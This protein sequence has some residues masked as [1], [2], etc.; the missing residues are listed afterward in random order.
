[1]DD[2]R[3]LRLQTA[4]PTGDLRRR[5]MAG[6]RSA[7][8][9]YGIVRRC[10][11]RPAVPGLPDVSVHLAQGPLRRPGGKRLRSPATGIGVSPDPEGAWLAAVSEAL[12]RYCIVWPVEG[13]R[14]LRASLAEVE[15]SAVPV[16]RFGLFSDD[17]YATNSALA[18][19]DRTDAI[20]WTWAYSLTSRRFLLVPA[21]LVHGSIGHG[22]PNNFGHG[23]SSTGVAS[24]VSVEAALLAGLLEVVERDAV[25]ISWLNRHSPATVTLDATT[26]R[27]LLELRQ[28]F[29]VPGI[30]FVLLDLTLDTGIPTVGC[31]ALSDRSDR[32]SAVMGSASRPDPVDAASKAL[33]EAAQ[34][35]YSLN[36]LGHDAS[37]SLPEADVRTFADHAVFYAGSANRR[38]LDFLA[39]SGRSR[40][41]SG[42][43][44]LSTGTTGGDL[45][46][47]VA[48]LDSVGLEV[49]VAELTTPDVGR[50][51]FR[52]FKVL[53]PGAVDI[54]GDARMPL[55]G[56]R[57]I[58]E[59]PAAMGWPAVGEAKLNLS[60]C[61]LP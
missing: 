39:S 26:S 7:L 17:Q 40:P 59:V 18:V 8:G 23:L 61:P 41:L 42:M 3:T 49:L 38:F 22:P 54:N 55:L 56:S 2:T 19:P 36:A 44:D 27:E 30:E 24:H 5:A 32:P 37:S 6:A 45:Q 16:S 31:L 53:V 29:E 21:A 10:R 46:A 28:R 58:D 25:M 35:H 60:P 12:E 1:M 9:V 13:W 4:P 51:G 15:G 52:V 47:C 48:L 34:I 14:L 50:L 33:L 20:D 43:R 11:E 57:R